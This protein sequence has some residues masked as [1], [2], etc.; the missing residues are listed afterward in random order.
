MADVKISVNAAQALANIKIFETRG[1]LAAFQAEAD[2][3]DEIIRL[4]TLEVPLDEGTLMN[5]GAVDQI[6]KH[7]AAGY[8]TP[9]A[10]RLHE[11]PEYHFRRGRKGKYLS[12]PISRN[13]RALGAHFAQKMKGKLK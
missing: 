4:S 9:Y 1:E 12:D 11:H 10:A 5:S 2:V 3:G 8:H 7:H 6:G 13:L